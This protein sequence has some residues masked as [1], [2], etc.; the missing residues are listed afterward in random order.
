MSYWFSVMQ[1]MV[2]QKYPEQIAYLRE[3]HGFTREHANALVLYSR[4][5]KTSRRFDS[6]DDYLAEHDSIKQATV[7]RIFQVLQERFPDLEL[8]IAWN[9]P[10]LKLDGR[11]IF[12]VS[13]LQGHLLMAPYDSDVLEKFRP[14]LQD[15]HLNKKTIR[16]PVDRE[17]DEGLLRDLVS[18]CR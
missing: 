7:R 16:I 1:E 2:P 17:V 14:R 4:G 13:V 5:S 8:V 3:N 6:L 11:Y 10:M 12:G 18:A 15:Y 9:T